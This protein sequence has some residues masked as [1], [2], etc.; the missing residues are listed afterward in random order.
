MFKYAYLYLL[1]KVKYIGTFMYVFEKSVDYVLVYVL[2]HMHKYAY[3][4]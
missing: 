1:Q 4:C 3:E 2:M